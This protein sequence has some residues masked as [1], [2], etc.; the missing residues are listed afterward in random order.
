[1][2]Q[3]NDHVLL[4]ALSSLQKSIVELK[5]ELAAQTSHVNHIHE[6]ICAVRASQILFEK[7]QDHTAAA[8]LRIERAANATKP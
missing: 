3:I 1:M 4:E 2:N 7:A 6:E 5:S 8:L